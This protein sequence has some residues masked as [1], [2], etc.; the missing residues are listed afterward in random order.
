MSAATPWV[1]R[2]WRAVE[3]MRQR[4]ILASLDARTLK[5]IGLE[6]LSEERHRRSLMH[7]AALRLGLY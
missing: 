7:S 6:A 4:R 2:L 3:D 1:R 5:D